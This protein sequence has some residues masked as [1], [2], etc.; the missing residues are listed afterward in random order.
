MTKYSF[1]FS[2]PLLA[3]LAKCPVHQCYSLKVIIL[4]NNKQKPCQNTA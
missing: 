4:E 2:P 3:F 1:V